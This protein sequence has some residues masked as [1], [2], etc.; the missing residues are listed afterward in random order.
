MLLTVPRIKAVTN[1]SSVQMRVSEGIGKIGISKMSPDKISSNSWKPNSR[2]FRMLIMSGSPPMPN[3]PQIPSQRYS[4][5]SKGRPSMQ[6]YWMSKG[7]VLLPQGSE[8]SKQSSRNK[9]QKKKKYKNFK[10]QK[11]EERVKI[12]DIL[13]QNQIKKFDYNLLVEQKIKA[14]TLIAQPYSSSHGFIE[15]SPYF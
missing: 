2:K 4:R 11:Q 15:S 6:N 13:R 5:I 12:E 14:N 9:C 1:R 8:F 10:F 3:S 7:F